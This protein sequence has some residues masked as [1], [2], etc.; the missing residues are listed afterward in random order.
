MRKLTVNQSFLI[1]LWTIPYDGPRL[2]PPLNA[3]STA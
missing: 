3:F 2:A 1:V